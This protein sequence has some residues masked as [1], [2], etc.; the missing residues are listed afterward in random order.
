[1]KNKIIL[2]VLLMF[3][4]AFSGC[5]QSDAANIDSTASSVNSHLK[6]GDSYY[7]KAATDLNKYSIETATTN[8]NKALSEF[9]SAKS[10]AQSGLNYAQSSKDNVFIEYMQLTVSEIDARINA[11]LEMQQA[12]NYLQKKDNTN[13]NPHVVLA[14]QYMDA[15]VAFK[16]KKD[17]II[18][19]NPSKF[20]S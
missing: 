7:N 11:T 14:N 17:N 5:I 15:S 2:L 16:V 19:Q 13:G 10:A 3:I 12:I 8:C 9:N 4:T 6:N 18:K 20:K 1:M